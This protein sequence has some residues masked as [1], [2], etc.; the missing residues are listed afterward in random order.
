MSFIGG[1][2]S[3]SS[4]FESDVSLVT[5][6]RKRRQS[7]ILQEA[8]ENA[9]S[10]PAAPENIAKETNSLLENQ[11]LKRKKRAKES[12][13]RA[14]PQWLPD[15]DK[16]LKE[17]VEKYGTEN[18][19]LIADIFA[20]KSE[21]HCIRRYQSA[22]MPPILRKSSWTP[23]ED[24][25]ISELVTKYG[26]KKWAFIASNLPGRKPKQCRERWHNHLQ[27]DI[28]K[29][30][31]TEKEDRIILD[32][33]QSEGNRWAEMA[34]KL[35]GR[36]DNSIKNHWNASMK[37]KII[38]YLADKQGVAPADLRCKAD[39]RFDFMNDFEGVLAAVR[40]PKV[41]KEQKQSKPT[42]VPKSAK[43]SKEKKE[44]AAPKKKS[45][46]TKVKP[47]PSKS[48][49]KAAFARK[50]RATLSWAPRETEPSTSSEVTGASLL[51]SLASCAETVS[52]FKKKE[53]SV[54]DSDDDIRDDENVAN[55][56][57][58][59]DQGVCQSV[60]VPNIETMREGVSC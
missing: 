47:S 22:L 35:P 15:E 2:Q 55:S 8:M 16:K 9:V 60:H 30:L 21:S 46:A 50:D 18:W 27:P 33:H 54:H 28:S 19:T 45:K 44:K 57:R 14:M 51:L 3:P 17:A 40:Q 58:P 52:P 11:E 37:R 23:E 4:E 39:G 36:T 29:A 12:K 42:K 49:L 59:I 1:K 20:N 26:A 56:Q 48:L 6:S 5:E 7:A 10:F 31:W 41:K 13:P 25:K 38:K 24:A 34:K 32:F 43:P 53:E